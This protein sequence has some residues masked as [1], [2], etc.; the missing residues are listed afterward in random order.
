MWFSRM[1]NVVVAWVMCDSVSCCVLGFLGFSFRLDFFLGFF[2]QSL[3]TFFVGNYDFWRQGVLIASCIANFSGFGSECA[4]N[5]KKF[6]CRRGSSRRF[7]E[8]PGGSSRGQALRA[9]SE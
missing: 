3:L 5:S 7:A 6:L 1:N 2:F 4:S 8:N 9:R